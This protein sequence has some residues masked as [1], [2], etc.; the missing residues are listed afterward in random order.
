M[1]TPTHFNLIIES[2]LSKYFNEQ[3]LKEDKRRE[4][5]A[6]IKEQED[7][8]RIKEIKRVIIDEYNKIT[9]NLYDETIRTIN[10][11]LLI[12]NCKLDYFSH[13]IIDLNN[14]FYT[15]KENP[16]LAISNP[17]AFEL[18]KAIIIFDDKVR[19]ETEELFKMDIQE[20]KEMIKKDK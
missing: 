7:K 19:N 14:N 9:N 15:Y 6:W 18:I 1:N 8:H 16:I 11:D 17:I 5:E 10:I 13:Y 3:K 4:H 12:S 2:Y 20:S